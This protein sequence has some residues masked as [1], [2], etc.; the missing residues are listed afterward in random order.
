MEPENSGVQQGG[1]QADKTVGGLPGRNEPTGEKGQLHKL[2]SRVKAE[3]KWIHLRKFIHPL[4][5]SFIYQIFTEMLFWVIKV[6]H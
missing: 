1:W 6:Y 2:S 3:Q 4:M 5:Y